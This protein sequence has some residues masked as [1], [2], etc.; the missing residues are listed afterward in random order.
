[1]RD[2]NY[3]LVQ[4]VRN[5]QCVLNQYDEPCRH[6]KLFILLNRQVHQVEERV[7]RLNMD[8]MMNCL[9]KGSAEFLD[10]VIKVETSLNAIDEEFEDESNPDVDFLTWWSRLLTN[11]ALSL[12][13]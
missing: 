1:M 8:M 2:R 12:S 10:Y 3:D 4:Q 6:M 11:A 7:Q 9:M 13:R 5:C